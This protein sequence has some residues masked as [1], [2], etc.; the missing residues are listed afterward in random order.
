KFSQMGGDTMNVTR[1]GAVV[2]TPYYMSP[3]QA[4]GSS[5]IDQRTDIYAIGVLLYQATTGQVPYQAQTFNHLPFKI[6]LEVAPPP[7]THV[8][9]VDPELSG[10]ILRAMSR[11]PAQRFQSCREFKEALLQYQSNQIHPIPAYPL[12]GQAGGHPQTLGRPDQV[13]TEVLDLNALPG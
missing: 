4:R 3:E 11:E 6:V 9:D 13:R 5:A 2:G 10:I 7:E 8:P 1:V 12:P